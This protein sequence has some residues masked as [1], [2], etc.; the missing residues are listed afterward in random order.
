MLNLLFYIVALYFIFCGYLYLIQERMIFLP[1]AVDAHL[2]K[3][4]SDNEIILENDKQQSHGWQIVQQKQLEKTLLYF[5]GNAEDVVFMNLES[6]RFDVK[7]VIAIN[8]PG[9]GK[10]H[11]KPGQSELYQQALGN[12]DSLLNEKQ[13]QLDSVVLMG[14]SLGSSV[15][16]Y[17]ASKRNVAGLILATPFDSMR[18]VAANHYRIFPVDF[19]LKHP[20]PT[21][22]FITDVQCPVIVVA[23]E[24]DEIIAEQNLY[25]L[26]QK[27]R[28]LK[29]SYRYAGF[30]HNTLQAHP[31]YY[32][33]INAFIRDLP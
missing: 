6:E 15:A 31:D 5:G 27:I 22:D 28:Q 23:A 14:R 32:R 29:K 2:Y 12:F 25:K 16:A 8:Y 1:P 11:G 21:T 3:R 13:I 24:K 20:F 10:S 19:L 7:Q 18:E 4:F 30:G 33:D 17:V 26:E 9:Y